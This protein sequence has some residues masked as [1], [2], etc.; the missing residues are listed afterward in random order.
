[1]SSAA[2]PPEAARARRPTL[3]AV[4]ARAGVG[5]G[6]VSRVI[7]GSPKVSAHSRAAVEQ[8]IAE[9]GYVPNRAA[10]SL[11]TRRTDSVALVVPESETRLFSEPYFSAIIRGVS[12]GL[13]GAGM[14]LLLVLVRDESERARLA[15]Y[16]TEQRVDGVLMVAVHRDDT[17]PDLLDELAIPTV[18]AGRRGHPEPLGHVRADNGGGARAAV[19]HLLEGDRRTI[20]TITGPLDMDVARARLDGYREALQTA[21][22]TVDE[23]LIAV[24]DF[25]EE[26]GRAAMR[27][28]LR[29]RP[30]LDAVFAASDVTASGA[31]LEL[32]AAGRRV[33]DDVAV[34]GFDDSIVARHTD[35]P[36]TSVRQPIEEMGRTMAR[37]LL[38]EIAQR[39]KGHREVVL[40]TELVVRK[41]A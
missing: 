20:A 19:R 3:D 35:P 11:V 27:E 6:T 18:L 37:L 33:P 39:G 7:N 4:A 12:S 17:L 5:R 9:L 16:L 14:Q 31:V 15:T 1:M 10:R 22:I 30:H 41:S 21:G 25:T 29:R 8:A 36:L 32:R 38:E 40:P 23:E 28:L 2:Q 13:S 24:G 34:I 26:G